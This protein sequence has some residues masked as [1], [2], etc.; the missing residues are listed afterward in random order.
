MRADRNLRSAY[1]I[2]SASPAVGDWLQAGF[3]GIAYRLASLTVPRIGAL[4]VVSTFFY[5]V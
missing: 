2:S 5:L 4:L 1:Q 3:I